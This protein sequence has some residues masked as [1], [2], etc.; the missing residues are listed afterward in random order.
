MSAHPPQPAAASAT[1]LALLPRG[2]FNPASRGVPMGNG[3]TW[4]AAAWSLFRAAAGTWIGML[5]ALIVIGFVANLLPMIGPLVLTVLWPVFIAGLMIASRTLEDGNE[6]KF[7][8]LFAGFQQ[9]FGPLILLGVISLVISLAIV[10]AV[11]AL[12]GV[13][14]FAIGT[15]TSPEA[16]LTAMFSI[17]F[18]GLLMAALMLP[19][20][21]A[22]WFAPALIVFHDMGVLAAMKASFVG[23]M[24]NVLPF[25]LYGVIA[26]VA[27]AIAS[28]PFLLGWLVLGPLL[29]ASVYTGYRDIYFEPI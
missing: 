15:A 18:A 23:C 27:G 4:F 14:I 9:R 11:V 13:Q 8:V 24:K 20:V 12:T 26:L 28:V 16:V 25:L 21:M 1:A 19:L 3:W 7:T 29:F 17:A 5:L 2:S 6:P 10:F 22:T